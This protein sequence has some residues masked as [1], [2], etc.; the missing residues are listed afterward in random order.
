VLLKL[1]QL[2]ICMASV[3]QIQALPADIGQYTQLQALVL[4]SNHITVSIRAQ[5]G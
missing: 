5:L 1:P 4:Q 3:N 2:S